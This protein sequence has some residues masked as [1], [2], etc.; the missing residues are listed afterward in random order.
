MGSN[1]FKFIVAEIKDGQYIQYIDIRKTAG[2][3]DDLNKSKSESGRK[4]ISDHKLKD[5]K[6]MLKDFQDQ[7]EQ[8]TKSR[9]MYAIATAAFREAENIQNISQEIKQLDIELQVLSGEDESIYAYEAATL[10]EPGFTV[11]DLGSRTTEFVHRVGEKYQWKEIPTGYKIAWDEFYVNSET[12]VEGFSKHI[13]KLKEMFA[14]TEEQILNAEQ[15]LKIIEVGETASYV[16]GIPQ[17]QIE[18][19]VITQL[20]IRKT[21]NQLFAMDRKSFMKLKK[22]FKDAPKVLPR[23]VLLDFILAGTA[24]E[25][26]TATDR[27]LNVTIVYKRSRSE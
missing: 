3:G 27:Q 20:Q 6:A 13:N 18:G 23:L 2:V 11:V 22:D 7:C 17:D 19:K 25:K 5:M 10:G 15:A 4:L 24:H 1:T 12:F 21:L 14:E 26:F 8:K 16:L 9:K